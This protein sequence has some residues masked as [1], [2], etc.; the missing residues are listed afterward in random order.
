VFWT[1]Q[2]GAHHLVA[3]GQTAEG[4]EVWSEPIRFEVTGGEEGP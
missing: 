1:L 3:V 4:G 2:P